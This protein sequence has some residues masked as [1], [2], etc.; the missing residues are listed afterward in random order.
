M[1]DGN[2]G[3]GCCMKG[4]IDGIEVGSDVNWTC[5]GGGV[6]LCDM[7]TLQSLGIVEKGVGFLDLK[8]QFREVLAKSLVIMI[9]KVVEDAVAEQVEDISL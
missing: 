4:V 3:G 8:C 6:G 1:L 9:G 2:I 5:G 7:A